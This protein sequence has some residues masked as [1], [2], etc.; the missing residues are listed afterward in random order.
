MRDYPGGAQP[1]GELK[2]RDLDT[3]PNAF[4]LKEG[5]ICKTVV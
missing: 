5:K 4:V 1:V 2:Q 3:R